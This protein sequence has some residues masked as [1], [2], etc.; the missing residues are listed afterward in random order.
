MDE[1][2]VKKEFKTVNRVMKVG[3]P[4]APGDHLEP[5]DFASLLESGFIG[6]KAVVS[7]VQAAPAGV[8]GPNVGSPVPKGAQA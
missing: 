5:H 1:H 3:M 6:P 7:A 4:V 2:L 8:A